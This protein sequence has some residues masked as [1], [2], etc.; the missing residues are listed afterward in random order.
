MQEFSAYS[1]LLTWEQGQKRHSLDRGLLLYALAAPN[2]ELDELADRPLGQRNAA[3]LGL[4]RRLFGDGLDA[5]VDCPECGEKLEFSVS[6]STLLSQAK[7]SPAQIEV[8]GLQFRL[9]TTRDLAGVAGDLDASSAARTLLCSLLVTPSNVNEPTALALVP[10]VAAALE[11]ADP[12][13]DFV[14]EQQ[15][16]P[17]GHKWLAS[18]DVAAF[19]WDEVET[20][21]RRLLDEV[22]V[23]A[24]A[25]GWTEQEIFSLT[26]ARRS[27]YLERVLA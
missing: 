4:R 25:Y 23:L 12:C 21:A 15:C 27:A 8:E 19:V 2:A 20:R 16:P 11:E 17:C 22:H 1:L 10:K 5:C 18:F 7:P 26:D 13:V 9:P 6:A 3:L 14:L 24:R